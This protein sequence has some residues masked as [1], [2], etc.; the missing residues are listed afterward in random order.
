MTLYESRVIWAQISTFLSMEARY[1]IEAC[2]IIEHACCSKMFEQYDS[3]PKL[4]LA[5]PGHFSGKYTE[6][7]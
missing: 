1:Q 5:H 4:N 6:G 2:P 7:H 3:L